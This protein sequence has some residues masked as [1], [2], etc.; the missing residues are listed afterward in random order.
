MSCPGVALAQASCPDNARDGLWVEFADRAVFY[1]VLSDGRISEMEFSD[2]ESRPVSGYVTHPVGLVIEGWTLSGARIVP[3][4]RE[5]VTHAGTPAQLP[6]PVPGARFDGLETVNYGDGTSQRFSV[7]LVVG[8]AQPVTIGGCSYT[9][10]PIEVTRI[11]IAAGGTPMIE[12]MLHLR[13]LA[14]TIYL[15]FSDDGRPPDGSP[16]LGISRNPPGWHDTATEG[17]G[18]DLL[19]PP[20]LPVPPAPPTG[21]PEK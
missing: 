17:G 18:M 1:R 19:P 5:T 7:N 10:L 9:G 6:L 12:A 16:P 2:D 3:A 4:D 14:L 8:Q 20:P 11:D 15:D 13:E 21:A